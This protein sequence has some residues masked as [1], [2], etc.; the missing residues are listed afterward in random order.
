LKGAEVL[1][2]HILEAGLENHEIKQLDQAGIWMAVCF[3]KGI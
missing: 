2:S 3:Q 1:Y